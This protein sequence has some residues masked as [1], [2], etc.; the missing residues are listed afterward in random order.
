MGK[1]VKEEYLNDSVPTKESKTEILEQHIYRAI[2]NGT[3]YSDLVRLIR[4]DHWKIGLTYSSDTAAKN[5]ITRVK[6]RIKE[7]WI[8]ESKELRENLYTKMMDL[9]ADC[10][11]NNDRKVA[12]DILKTLAKTTG[13]AEPEKVDLSISGGIEID[14]GF[15]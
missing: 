1:K 4:L 12:N 8:E 5:V 13:V 6:K 7:D 9:Y 11:K 2:M 10:R 14:F 15:E 3:T